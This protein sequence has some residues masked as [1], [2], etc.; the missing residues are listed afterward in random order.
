L[1]YLWSWMQTLGAS[2]RHRDEGATMVEYGMLVDA[3][4][5][6]VVVGA[7]ALGATVFN[8]FDQGSAAVVPGT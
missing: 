4:A 6:V 2:L 3:I 5:L 1:L 8:W 7:I